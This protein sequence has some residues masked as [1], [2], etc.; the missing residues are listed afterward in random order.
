MGSV[1]VVG[2]GVAGCVAAATALELGYSVVVHEA[3]PGTPLPAE[4]RSADF[5]RAQGVR[6]R[7]WD[8]PYLAGKGIGGGSAVNGMVLQR[9]TTGFAPEIEWV[10]NCLNPVEGEPGPLAR[11]LLDVVQLM[12]DVSG[13]V[14]WLALRRRARRTAAD[15]WLR[16]HERLTVVSDSFIEPGDVEGWIDS[17]EEVL[18]AAGALRSPGVVGVEPNA[19]LDHPSAVIGFALPTNLRM[20]EADVPVATVLIRRDNAQL[21]VLDRAGPDPSRGAIVVSAMVD[22]PKSRTLEAGLDLARELMFAIGIDFELM[23]GAAP[24]AHACCTLT[25]IDTPVPVVDASTLSQLPDVNPMLTVAAHA[26]RT[27]L[28]ALG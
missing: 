20:T 3:G 16:H 19:A 15:A 17:G 5:N 24:V 21:L 25:G 1:I 27:T 22:D 13:E 11:E 7:W 9:P 10:W 4:L 14:A 23:S 26:R 28:E 8:A 6:D 12:P 18:V 2:A